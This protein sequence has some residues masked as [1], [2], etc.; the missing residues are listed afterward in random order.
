MSKTDETLTAA[1]PRHHVLGRAARRNERDEIARVGELLGA[2]PQV[3][4]AR[5]VGGRWGKAHETPA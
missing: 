5:G 3:R 4:R 2:H 1:H